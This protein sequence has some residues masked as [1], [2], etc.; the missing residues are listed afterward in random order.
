M[1]VHELVRSHEVVGVYRLVG[2]YKLELH[3]TTGHIEE[4][5]CEDYTTEGQAKKRTIK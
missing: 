5:T 1:R 4:T 3:K 2:A